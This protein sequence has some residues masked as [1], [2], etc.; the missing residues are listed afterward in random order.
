MRHSADRCDADPPNVLG[1]WCTC[2]NLASCTQTPKRKRLFK[3]L[4]IISCDLA[5]WS[6][7]RNAGVREHDIEL[8]LL[9]LDLR[10][11]A[12]EVAEICNVSLDTG[13]IVSDL[14]YSR[15]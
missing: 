10:E 7:L 11:E 14:L 6:I 8:G 15:S 1:N 13:H 9:P 3:V 5:E 12:I 2:G 4:R